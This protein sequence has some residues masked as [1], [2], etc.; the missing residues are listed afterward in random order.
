M[1][2]GGSFGGFKIDKLT[3]GNYHTWR[4]NIELVLAFRE[5]DEVVFNVES[6]NISQDA[7]AI[8]EFRKT[9]AKAKAVIGL[10][11]MNI[12]SMSVGPNSLPKCG[13]PSRMCSSAPVCSTSWPPAA[14]STLFRRRM[15]RRY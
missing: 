5:L 7:A 9:D 11:A 4:Q 15:V 1:D 12:W 13:W 2:Q 8:A 14:A 6:T 3:T 10:S